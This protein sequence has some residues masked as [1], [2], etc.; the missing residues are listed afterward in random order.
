MDCWERGS[1]G[2][3]VDGPAV[4]GV[5]GR[6]RGE[7]GQDGLCIAQGQAGRQAGRLSEWG[8]G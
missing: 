5:D 6:G 3:S 2:H 7:L 4:L 1:V 8:V